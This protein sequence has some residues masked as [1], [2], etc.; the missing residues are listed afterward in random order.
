MGFRILLVVK[1]RFGEAKYED[2]AGTRCYGSTGGF[3]P[4]RD[5]S[6]LSVPTIVLVARESLSVGGATV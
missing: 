6:T 1:R 5:S 4:L 3:D 2:S